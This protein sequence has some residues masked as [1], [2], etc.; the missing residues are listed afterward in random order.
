M[1]AA[2]T[3]D[4]NLFNT[5]AL[6]VAV[7]SPLVRPLRIA[8]LRWQ[9]RGQGDANIVRQPYIL[10]E[11]VIVDILNGAALVP[12]VFLVGSVF[13]SDVLR[14][15]LD[16]S[17]VLMGIAGLIGAVLVIGEIYR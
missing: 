2:V 4:I 15:A 5:A 11:R 17:R 1:E 6:V 10:R 14:M 13:S 3:I 9:L 12:Y 7:V 16:G 8:L